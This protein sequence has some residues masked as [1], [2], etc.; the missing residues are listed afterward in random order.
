MLGFALVL[1]CVGCGTDPCGTELLSEVLSPDG[2]VKAVAFL[3]NCGAT[4]DYVT[5]ISLAAPTDDLT[6][7]S[8]FFTPRRLG[9]LF[10]ASGAQD[11]HLEWR[12]P[13]ALVV[14]YPRGADA[15][16]RQ[17]EHGEI[18]ITYK[19]LPASH[20]HLN[21]RVGAAGTRDSLGR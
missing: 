20:T 17:P 21:L 5:A 1:G 13:T 15:W 8:R 11:L 12:S 7:D 19:E 14:S 16:L 2:K 9:T 10:R 4:T 6:A 3:R 18:R